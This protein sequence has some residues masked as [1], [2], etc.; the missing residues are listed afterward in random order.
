M[1]FSIL[2]QKRNDYHR[3][4]GW[5][6]KLKLIPDRPQII[7]LDSYIETLDDDPSILNDSDISFND[8]LN[9]VSRQDVQINLF[10]E[11]YL[12]SDCLSASLFREWSKTQTITSIITPT[13][14][15]AINFEL[16]SLPRLEF[17]NLR[18]SVRDSVDYKVTVP[19]LRNDFLQILTQ[20]NTDR[21]VYHDLKIDEKW[22]EQ[23]ISLK[24]TEDYHLGTLILIGKQ[25]LIRINL[26]N[27]HHLN[28]EQFNLLFIEMGKAFINFMTKR[29]LDV[30]QNIL[31]CL[32]III[33]RKLTRSTISSSIFDKHIPKISDD[34]AITYIIG[35]ITEN[36]IEPF[37]ILLHVAEQINPTGI[38]DALEYLIT[39]FFKKEKSG[40][41]MAIFII[42]KLNDADNLLHNA[43]QQNIAHR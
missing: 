22:F 13:I 37:A 38:D 33:E 10:G 41:D 25:L 20:L 3:H 39:E 31:D 16:P 2:K 36:P 19:P 34:Y 32:K 15:A 1:K 6:K 28:N 9:F 23:N 4:K 40:K 30:P 11:D 8:F 42:R 14:P 5:G 27:T 21:F 18:L 24:K 43:N 12:N 17:Q 35:H 7:F 29:S 26:L